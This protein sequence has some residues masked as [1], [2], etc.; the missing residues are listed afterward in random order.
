MV[1]T[2][3]RLGVG[4]EVV[5]QASGGWEGSVQSASAFVVVTQVGLG[6]P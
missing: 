3:D 4:V 5:A 1:R 6:I 2:A